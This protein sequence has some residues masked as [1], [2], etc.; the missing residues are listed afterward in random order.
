MRKKRAERLSIWRIS[1]YMSTLNFLLNYF[2]IR[3]CQLSASKFLEAMSPD[4]IVI[5]CGM[6]NRHSHPIKSVVELYEEMGI[7][8]Y[9]TDE[10]GNIVMTTDGTEYSFDKK[11]GTYTSG[12]EYKEGN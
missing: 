9:R 3:H 10:S 12:A 11:P 5:S 1:R 7:T 2:F 4:D 6:K 8:V